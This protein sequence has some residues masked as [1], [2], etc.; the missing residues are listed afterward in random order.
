MMKTTSFF[1][2]LF[3]TFRLSAQTAE[4]DSLKEARV[5]Q[6]VVIAQKDRL[7]SGVPGAASYVKPLELRRMAPLTGNEVFRKLPGV[8]VVDEEGIGLRTNIGIRGLNPDRSSNVLVLEDGIPVQLNPYG[9]PEMYY[10]PAIDRMSAIEVV[11]G[12]GQILFGPR[13]IGGVVNYITADPPD[14]PETRIVLKGGTGGFFSSQLQYGTTFGNTGLIVNYLHKQADR[15]GVTGFRVDDLNAKLN[16]TLGERSSVGLKLQ[17]YDET[18]NSTYVGLTQNM[19]EAGNYYPV[20]APDDELRIRRYA[21][22][23]THKY[24]ISSNL[25]LRTSAYAYTISRDWRRQSFTSDGTKP[26][27]TGVVWGDASIPNG[28]VFM[29]NESGLRNRSFA[30]GGVESKLTWDYNIGQRKHQLEAGGRILG[31]QAHEVEHLGNSPDSRSGKLVADELRPGHAFSGFI[32]NKFILTSHLAVTAGIRLEDY[33]FERRINLYKTGSGEYRDTSIA[34]PSHVSALIPGIGFNYSW[35]NNA[36]FFGGIHKGFAPPAIKNS[37][38]N[39]GEVF[40]LDEQASWNYELGLRSAFARGFEVELTGF[41]LDF[42]KQVIPL[43][44]S[45]GGSGSGFANAGSTAHVGVEAS[46]RLDFGKLFRSDYSVYWEA[47][48]TWSRAA[49]SADRF[50]GAEKTNVKDNVLPYAPAW[51]STH[52][53]GFSAPWRLDVQVSGTYVSGQFTD[54]LNTD[55]PAANGRTGSIPSYFVMDASARYEFSSWRTT[56]F[57]SM[58]NLGDTRYIASRRPTGIKVGLP[59]FLAAGVETRF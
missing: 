47:N 1:A 58:K 57:I 10:T 44:E 11:K 38:S 4:T 35:K 30:V 53:L 28:A 48:A 36:T 8:H 16:F 45:S 31:E 12:S 49:F 59:R 37:V 41:Y 21:L 39:T 26:N 34:A 20:M 29:L 51:L 50:I 13:T 6:V 2:L 52:T 56:L 17:V 42:Q 55:S 23:A 54:E 7:L 5:P 25:K 32:Q 33:R 9:E 43:S 14:A 15:I 46:F 22:A 18:S 27:R 19:F 40:A 3:F 24:F